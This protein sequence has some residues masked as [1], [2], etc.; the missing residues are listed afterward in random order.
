MLYG[1]LVLALLAGLVAH[2]LVPAGATGAV[3]AVSAFATFLVLVIW[4]RLNRVAISRLDEP[5]ALRRP[6]IRP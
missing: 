6:L 2:G 3:D 1:T 5:A 4:T